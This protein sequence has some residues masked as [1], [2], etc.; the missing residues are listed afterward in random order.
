[1][2]ANDLLECVK[3][4][5]YNSIDCYDPLSVSKVYYKCLFKYYPTSLEKNGDFVPTQSDWDVRKLI[6]NFKYNNLNT[7]L[8]EHQEAVNNVIPHIADILIKTFGDKLSHITLVCIPAS[9]KAY[10]ERRFK[11][12]AKTLC[13]KLNI[14]NGYDYVTISEEGEEKHLGGNKKVKYLLD[15]SY[16]E[17]KNVIVFD[18]IITKCNSMQKM[19]REL[20]KVKANFICSIAIGLTCH[21]RE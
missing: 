9:T 1:M 10:T 2:G 20:E 13:E 17:N 7:T 3:E 12:F 19:K 18:D 5:E 15:K 4:W 6:W 8:N 14:E 11:D 21:K 16:F